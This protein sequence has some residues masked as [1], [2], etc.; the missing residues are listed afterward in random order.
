MI[1]KVK[2]IIETN[3]THGYESI[4]N[5]LRCR[6]LFFSHYQNQKELVLFTREDRMNPEH[7]KS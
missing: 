4:L 2:N 3:S 1:I 5:N 6:T 7:K